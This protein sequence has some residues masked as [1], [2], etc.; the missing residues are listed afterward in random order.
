MKNNMNIEQLGKINE[1]IKIYTIDEE[2]EFSNI[3]SILDIIN[4][5][6]HTDNK[7]KLEEIELELMNKLK[8]INKNHNTNILIIGKNINKYKE[9]NQS[10]EKI[11]KDLMEK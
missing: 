1:K 3:K 6:Y 7:I 8:K 5:N 10:T 2:L 9:I 11:F 4:C